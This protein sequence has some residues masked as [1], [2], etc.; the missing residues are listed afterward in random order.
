MINILQM[1]LALFW[2][3]QPVFTKALS[4]NSPKLVAPEFVGRDT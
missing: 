1:Y 4:I 3:L 2:S